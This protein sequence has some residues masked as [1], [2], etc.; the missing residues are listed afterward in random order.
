MGTACENG[1][2]GKESKNLARNEQ[3]I[4]Q[5]KILQVLERRRYGVTLEELRS[6]VVEELGLGTLHTRSIRRDI[7][8][9]Q[10]A[11]MP[12]STQDTA[13]AVSYTHL[14]APRDS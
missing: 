14:R 5:H 10:S 9:L 12:I 4:R 7:E 11:G 2:L 13:R 8:A 3:L 6:N 1:A